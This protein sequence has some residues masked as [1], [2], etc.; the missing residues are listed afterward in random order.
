MQEKL[1]IYIHANDLMHPSWFIIAEDGTV[2]QTALH[3]DV[4]GLAPLSYDKI[5]IVIV[6]GEDVL[7]TQVTVPKMNRSRLLKTIPFALEDELIFDVDT[8][9]FALLD[10]QVEGALPVAVVTKEKMHSWLALLSELQIAPDQFIPATLTLPFKEGSWTFVIDDL[11]MVRTSFY[12]GF[13][14]DVTS[15]DTL[16]KLA[17]EKA[18][19][20]PVQMDC[21]QMTDANITLPLPIE[22]S[23]QPMNEKDKMILLAHQAANQPMLN[24]LQGAYA[25]KKQR[26]AS[27]LGLRNSVMSLAVI[28]IGLLFAYPIVSY[29]ILKAR[30]DAIDTQIAVIYKR[31]FPQSTEVVAP[32][33]RLEEKLRRSNE[34]S[35]NQLLSLLTQVGGGL[36]KVSSIKLK[37]FDYQHNQLILIVTAANSDDFTAF[38]DYLT[39]QGL[40]VKQ[41]NATLTGERIDA[42]LLVE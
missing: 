18:I 7:L 14:C 20:K 11:I 27:L 22:C 8:L 1:V 29:F 24:L 32:K 13:V 15:A 10:D 3:D 21:Y 12:H 35:G 9:H 39:Q 4:T 28:W 31:H 36:T 34:A 40:T 6:P 2:R 26:K 41:Q 17:Y 37:R 38:T 5:V 19:V 33:L 23:A 25:V 30:L 16:I 42:T